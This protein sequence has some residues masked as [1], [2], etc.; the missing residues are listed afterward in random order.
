MPSP[1][2]TPGRADQLAGVLNWPSG[3]SDRFWA[4]A[5]TNPETGCMEWSGYRNDKGYGVVRVV[6]SIQLAHRVA[7]TI[8]NG[9]I[10]AGLSLDHLCRNRSCINPAHLEPVTHAENIRR[11]PY[12]TSQTNK[13]KTHCQHGHEFTPDNTAMYGRPPARACRTCMRGRPR[14][15]YRPTERAC[16]GCGRTYRRL[17]AHIRRCREFTQH[18]APDHCVGCRQAAK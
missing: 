18:P 8:A 6:P 1:V 5:V 16:P 9:I 4:K 2:I 3:R 10:P 14:Q 11:S 7:W 15:P 17:D 12:P 13:L